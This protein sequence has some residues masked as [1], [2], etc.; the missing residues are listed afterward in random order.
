TRGPPPQCSTSRWLRH[1]SVHIKI[2]KTD[3]IVL[4]DTVLLS[5]REL[6]DVTEERKQW[7]VFCSGSL[8]HAVVASKRPEF[9][10]HSLRCQSGASEAAAAA[11]L[12]LDAA[13]G[14]LRCFLC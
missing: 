1:N 14:D 6:S 10:P 9:A 8:L 4:G 7:H 11:G 12:F 13:S 3:S 2:L 5:D